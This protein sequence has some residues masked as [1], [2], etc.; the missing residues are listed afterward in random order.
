VERAHQRI[1]AAVPPLVADRVLHT[2]IEAME[3]LVR[4][5][6]FSRIHQEV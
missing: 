6:A 1:R 5:G 4:A 3:A 2:D